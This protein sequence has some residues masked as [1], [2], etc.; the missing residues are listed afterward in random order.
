MIQQK[1][2]I[3]TRIKG[4]KVKHERRGTYVVVVVDVSAVDPAP[5]ALGEPELSA[6]FTCINHEYMNVISGQLFTFARSDMG[7][8]KGDLK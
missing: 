2:A 5:V 6:R 8:V 4:S 7:R 1:N 3:Y